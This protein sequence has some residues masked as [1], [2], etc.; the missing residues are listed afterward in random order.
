MY[1]A[2]ILL[3]GKGVRNTGMLRFS[4]TSIGGQNNLAFIGNPK[5]LEDKIAYKMNKTPDS[6]ISEVPMDQK[7]MK[8]PTPSP[9]IVSVIMA[10]GV[11][12]DLEKMGLSERKLENGVMQNS[13]YTASP[14][15]NTSVPVLVAVP[16][17][18]S[19]DEE[20]SKSAPPSPNTISSVDEIVS[21]SEISG[22]LTEMKERN[23]T[24]YFIADNDHSISSNEEKET[25]TVLEMLDRVLE[26]EGDVSPIIRRNS[27]D[28]LNSVFIEDSTTVQIHQEDQQES[29]QISRKME[30]VEA[31]DDIEKNDSNLTSVSFSGIS[32]KRSSN[33]DSKSESDISIDLLVD[34]RAQFKKF[35]TMRHQKFITQL[36]DIIGQKANEIQISNRPKITNA[37]PMDDFEQR[38]GHVAEIK[39]ALTTSRSV[40]NLQILSSA[41]GDEKKIS[42]GQ[43]DTE[44]ANVQKMDSIEISEQD[45]QHQYDEKPEEENAETSIP[46]APVFIPE[47]YNTVR[48]RNQITDSTLDRSVSES[49]RNNSLESVNIPAAPAFN[50]VLYNSLGPKL[51]S[52]SKPISIPKVVLRKTSKDQTSAADDD[53]R[54]ENES[55]TDE[56]DTSM[57]TLKGKLEQIYSRGPPNR[58]S[59]RPKI[60]KVQNETSAPEATSNTQPPGETATGPL[61]TATLTTTDTDDAKLEYVPTEDISNPKDTIGKQK[62]IFSIVL[63]TINSTPT[64]SSPVRND[65]RNSFRNSSIEDNNI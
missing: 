61:P 49:T 4:K 37:V 56:E 8:Y 40:P 58:L 21:V 13:A 52:I 17:T 55:N 51:D 42:S 30:S 14:I 64:P 15:A 65:I 25:S 22:S 48:S 54:I 16:S 5:G 34:N 10:I 47:I 36:N 24:A 44:D 43:D 1:I 6:S 38:T 60:A 57:S 19:S 28:S 2:C 35:G 53:K 7:N 3:E 33:E 62:A 27:V 39:A 63:K 45:D 20:K 59:F 31:D 12:N 46:A 29:A 11:S 26:E 32:T 23:G 9:G 41:G 18:S 50:P